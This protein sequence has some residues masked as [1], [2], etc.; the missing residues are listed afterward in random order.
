MKGEMI[1]IGDRVLFT[2]DA[3]RELK[4]GTA[5]EFSPSGRRVRFGF[6]DWFEVNLVKVVEVLVPPQEATYAA[7]RA[8]V[9][10]HLDEGTA[11]PSATPPTAINS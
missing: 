4:E 11:A 10:L 3:D 6:G 1:E 8:P 5:K 9:A 2:V 7:L